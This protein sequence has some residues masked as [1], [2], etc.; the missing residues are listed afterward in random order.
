M[1]LENINFKYI[2]LFENKKIL[3]NLNY[4]YFFGSFVITT[5]IYPIFESKNLVE[6]FRNSSYSS[7]T[8]LQFQHAKM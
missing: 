3:E 1:N 7:F 2:S 8:L 6:N 4:T 5:E